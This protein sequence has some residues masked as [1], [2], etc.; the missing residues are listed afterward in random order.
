[1]AFVSDVTAMTS[2]NSVPMNVGG[3][4]FIRDDLK[5][6][7]FAYDLINDCLD[8]TEAVKAKTVIYLPKP[9]PTDTTPANDARYKDYVLRA[10]FYNVT[11]RTALGL[12]GSVFIRPPEVKA[13]KSLEPVITDSNGAGISLEQLARDAEW[14]VASCGRAGLFIDYPPTKK[15]A[16]KAQLASGNIRPTMVVYGPKNVINWRTRKI[17]SKEVLCLVVLV[18]RYTVEDN[19]FE[20][21]EAIQ[22]R[23]LR[24][25]DKGVYSV[26]LWRAPEPGGSNY[27]KYGD[28]YFP[29]DGNGKALDAIPFTFIGSKNNEPTIDP[30]PLYDMASINI[31]HYRNSADYEEM[32]YV[33]G[34]PTLV[35]TGLTEE[36]YKN[37]LKG[38]V[39]LGSRG[40]IPLPVGAE[41][42][43][44]QVE[45]NT[46]AFEAMQHKER[47]MV[48]LGAKLVQQSEVQR[49]AAE[50]GAETASE[51]SIISAIANNVS[52]AMTW[53]LEWCAVFLNLPETDILF[54]LSID[55]T[56]AKLSN[57][58]INTVIKNWQAGALTWGEMRA[59]LKKAGQATEDDKK[60]LD[61]IT[62]QQQEAATFE[63]SLNEPAAPPA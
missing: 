1:M 23:E 5:A 52:A 14:L 16:T 17:G 63:A 54:K 61:E 51:E 35:L 29:L 31:A 15:V 57:D 38:A 53:G 27:T 30:A 6:R 32:V 19:G 40:G 18:E 7:F 33:I 2:A 22:Y 10:A 62:K 60:A 3:V 4:G 47:Q 13:P 45:E 8:G 24:L 56:L 26:Q 34:Q 48:A 42:E 50:S 43:I 11:Q 36:W 59:I 28:E 55:S 44:L 25:S 46:A 37:V 9:D 21:K 58:E 39:R 12:Q 49:T 41:A 20:T